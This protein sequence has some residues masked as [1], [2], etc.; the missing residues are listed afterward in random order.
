MWQ[1]KKTMI[2]DFRHYFRKKIILML[3]TGFPVVLPLCDIV[4][5]QG[6]VL[7]SGNYRHYIDSFNLNDNE[8]YQGYFPNEK[9]WELLSENIPLL[10]I[11]D[12]TV[13]RTYY[14]RWW[15]YR[16]HI[17]LT[18]D[19]FIITEFLPDVP[20]S[21]KYNS[22]SCPASHHF[23]EGRWL[24]DRR[25]LTDYAIFWFRHGGSIRTYSSWPANAIYNYYLVS[26]NDSLCRELF[27]DFIQN[28]KTWEK[29]K[30]DTNG[31]FWQ[32]DG[33]DGMEVSVC[34]SG[35]RA[36]INSYMFGEAVAI[37]DIALITGNNEIADTFKKKAAD[38][39][40][41]V[42]QKL[43][44][45]EDEFFKVLPREPESGL[46]DTRELHGYTPWYFSLPDPA[47]SVAWKFLMKPEYFYAQYGPTT[48]EQN[49]QGFRISYEGHECQWNGPSW[50]YA[51]S[52]TLTGI[53]NLLNVYDQNEITRND[54]FRLMKNYALSHQRKL[55]DGRTVPWIDENLNPY[56]GDWL[57]RT[58]LSTWNIGTWSE[59]K[60][61]AERG[62]DYNHSTFC[63][64]IITGLIGIRPRADNILEINPLVSENEWSYFC[65]DNVLYHNRI[66]TVLYDQTGKRYNKG[67][68]F[69]VLIDGKVAASAGSVKKITVKI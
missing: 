50:P 52:I 41:V 28:Y 61:G 37:S 39:K 49:S 18:P 19:G 60:G 4:V 33:N 3:L 25:Y 27:P 47:Y 63:D 12:K 66:I 31:L 35:Y 56:T 48:A 11:P 58:R 57:S 13:E 53:A 2:R 54:Y 32:I 8:L 64:L 1:L 9:C 45:P 62:K 51:T 5:A 14:F 43:W 36:T 22:I 46:C 15:T 42:Q 59:E 44:D 68:G 17:K 20:W 21:G 26:G 7:N 6:F 30:L 16:K 24:H 55:E 34:G 69:F 67:K 29:E 10:D 65:L 23:Y 40:N 38:I